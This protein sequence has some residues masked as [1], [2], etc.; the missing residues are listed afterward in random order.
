MLGYNSLEKHSGMSTEGEIIFNNLLKIVSVFY[1]SMQ[2]IE[3]RPPCEKTDHIV[4]KMVENLSDYF[5]RKMRKSYRDIPVLFDFNEEDVETQDFFFFFIDGIENL[6]SSRPPV[7][8]VS[9]YIKNG[10]IKEIYVF[11]PYN[12]EMFWKDDGENFYINTTKISLSRTSYSQTKKEYIFSNVLNNSLINND[13][14]DGGEDN[15]YDNLDDE[16]YDN[17]IENNDES[18]DNEMDNEFDKKNNDKLDNEKKNEEIDDLLEIKE[19]ENKSLEQNNIATK[20]SDNEDSKNFI[21]LISLWKEYIDV[22][23]SKN[24]IVYKV[25][26]ETEIITNIDNL[27][28]LPFFY[29]LIGRYTGIVLQKLD[30]KSLYLNNKLSYISKNIY[31]NIKKDSICIGPL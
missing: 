30:Y 19:V 15:S 4:N 8:M 7:A 1:D 10:R 31:E 18:Y 24:K 3:L 29:F 25:N 9:G 27:T 2:K 22:I 17:E 26:N 14:V 12:R 13:Y 21:D 16:S 6:K 28:I 23:I 20:L 11:D 5:L